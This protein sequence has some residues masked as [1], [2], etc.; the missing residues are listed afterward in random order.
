MKKT[1]AWLLLVVMLLGTFAGCGNAEQTPTTAAENGAADAIAYLKA[2]YKDAGTETFADFDRLGIVRIAGVAYTVVWT[3]DVAEDLIK[4]V[5][6]EDGSVTIDVNESN[7]TAT[8]YNLT[9]TVTDDAGNTAS[10]SWNYILPV[11]LGNDYGAIVDMAYELENGQAFEFDSTLVGTV[12]AINTAWSDEYKNITVTI[13]IEGREDKPIMCYRLKGEGAQDLAAGDL[14]TVTGKLKNYNGTIEFDS[15]CTLDKV[16]KGAGTLGDVPT[17]P[18][19]IVD[20]AFALE[21]G[22]SLPY[23]ATL[24][25]EVVSIDTPYSADYKNI[26]VSIKVEGREDK[27]IMCYR[28]KGE[29]ADQVMPGDTIT[30]S[31]VIKNYNGTIEFDA[32][33]SLVELI[34][35][36]NSFV[37]PSTTAELLEM[38][39][40]LKVG[41]AI[42][43]QV[44]LTGLIFAVDTP[45]SDRYGNISV[46]MVV[47]GM[48]DKPVLAFRMKGADVDKI[49]TNDTITVTG[50]LKNYNGTVEFDAGC[51]LDSW[52][53]TG[54]NPSYPKTQKE[55]VDALYAL[56]E[57]ET[58]HGIYS[59]TGRVVEAD[60]YSS[61]YGNQSITI[62]V[63]GRLVDVYRMTTGGVAVAE[64]D[65]VT[66]RGNLEDYKGSKQISSGYL[67]WYDETTLAEAMAECEALGDGGRLS[68]NEVTTGTIKITSPYSSQY[69]NISFELTDAY[70]TT[71]LCYRVKGYGM[72]NWV[73]GDT[74]T[75]SGKLVNFK[76]TAQYDSSARVVCQ[77][78]IPETLESQIEAA[79]FLSNGVYLHVPSTII[80][81][82]S[83]IDSPYSAQYGNISFYVTNEEGIEL[84][85]YR[86]KGD[87][88]DKLA[89]GDTVKV[90][91]YLTAYK[92]TA[93][94][95]S[96]A[97]V[98]ILEKGDG[99]YDDGK[100]EVTYKNFA[101]MVEAAS[102]LKNNE[103]LGV[104]TTQTGVI[105]DTP[106]Y[107]AKNDNWQFTMDVDGVEIY[108]YGVL[109]GEKDVKKGGIAT[110]TGDLTAYSGKAQFSYATVIEDS[111]T[112][113]AGGETP[114]E[115]SE[116]IE[117]EKPTYNTFAE[118]VEAAA[119]LANNKTL[120]VTTTQTGTIIDT[121]EFNDGY[122]NWSFTLD[123]DGVEIYCYA[124]L[125]GEASVVKGGTVKVT[126]DLT[127][128]GG[129][130]QFSNKTVTEAIYTA[131]AGGSEG[132]GGETPDTPTYNT[133]AEMVEAAA[134]LENNKTLG[135]TTT[136]TGTIIDTP[137]FND[138]YN[139]WSFTLDVDGVEIYCYALLKGEA[140]VVKGGTVKVTGDLTA[141]G[142]KP[143]FSNKTVTEAT[144]TAPAGGE[145]PDEPEQPDTPTGPEVATIEN[146]T[147]LIMCGNKAMTT[148]DA[149]YGYLPGT[150][151]TFTDGKATGYTQES[152][153]TI[154]NVTGGF[155]I[156]DSNGKVLGASAEHKTF[157]IGATSGTTYVA[158]KTATEGVVTIVNVDLN[159]TVCNDPAYGSFGNYAEVGTFL[160]DLYLIAVDATV[161]TPPTGGEGEGGETPDG[162]EGEGGTT[163][164][165]TK[166]VTYTFNFG[167]AQT[168][169]ISNSVLKT[170]FTND[171][172]A[173][174][175]ATVTDKVYPGNPSSGAFQG[176]YFLKLGTSSKAGSFT[177]TFPSNVKISKVI[178]NTHSWTTSENSSLTINSVQLSPSKTGTAAD[179][180][181]NLSTPSNVLTFTSTKRC[182]IFS[183][184]LEYTEG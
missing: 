162:G 52:I 50:T 166:T 77:R 76:G 7:E 93:Q 104:T 19:E 86:V 92:G 16:E 155:T 57:N 61:N 119:K 40:N 30:V 94:F 56:R 31:G 96:T 20:A 129:K 101:E 173:V 160:S 68:Y 51:K 121:P 170:A 5:V 146:G 80:G 58:F 75:V 69:N 45:Y 49:W 38:A 48:Y 89:L 138:G 179:L 175:S 156:T 140:S 118:M 35:G 95:D 133:F 148:K 124:L 90:E 111:Y 142:G 70:G 79:S 163:E 181:Y 14:I 141:Y 132:E 25:G 139:N 32:G 4:V 65:F 153:F 64:G 100:E 106:E 112:A 103:T 55:I 122:N 169:N 72:E 125:K 171:T 105:I 44:T 12:T 165:E 154:T 110:I 99:T 83:F 108:C 164:G 149:G 131:P 39:Y 174:E 15:G 136:Q 159:K 157:T 114:D 54:L 123:V 87:G 2:Y 176:A 172:L 11:G 60:A 126:G 23:T 43:V 183:V 18:L 78:I 73:D 144:Y 161:P 178:V 37:M 41:E 59:L 151:I 24:T 81:K 88:M 28:M 134:K 36:E 13:I 66:V 109:K 127:A 17:D 22:A 53:D 145:T 117:P 130:P 102:K 63:E 46:W 82:V 85:C 135:V 47:D 67:T 184:T 6:N 62:D 98:T 143:Q 10:H 167:S 97:T 21:V 42:P 147:Y 120:G 137:E 128:Y 168:N 116:P 115:P 107:Y 71:V 34:K 3:A 113:P 29:G 91:G 33:C 74:V 1:I 182:F 180:T 177:L 150:D 152:I 158:Y 26:T 84:Y 27:P 8:P 9:A